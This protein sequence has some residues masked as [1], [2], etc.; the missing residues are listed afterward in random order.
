MPIL[1]SSLKIYTEKKKKKNLLALP[2]SV[3]GHM[4]TITKKKKEKNHLAFFSININEIEDRT[5]VG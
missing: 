3:T 2:T 1:G 4:K 5:I